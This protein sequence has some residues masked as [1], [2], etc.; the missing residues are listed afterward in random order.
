MPIATGEQYRRML[1]HAK[2]E[3]SA[4]PAFNVT[5]LETLKRTTCLE[6]TARRAPGV[7]RRSAVAR[8]YQRG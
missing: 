7:A 1:D 8:G 2:R 4:Y 3:R 6:S 5:G